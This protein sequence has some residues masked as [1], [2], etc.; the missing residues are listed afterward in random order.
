MQ[1]LSST[2]PFMGRSVL[3]R[4]GESYLIDDT[5]NANPDSM[6]AAIDLLCSLPGRRVLVLGDMGELGDATASGHRE[7]GAYAK[8]K[9]IDALLAT[10]Q[11]KQF[12]ADGFGNQA[13]LFPDHNALVKALEH[14]LQGVVSALIK[15]SRSA[16]MEQVVHA[17]TESVGAH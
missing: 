10:G 12:Y 1:G 16:R 2:R 8:M 13:Q 9:K 11:H 14:E 7:V 3:H 4:L 5:Y 15:G 6:K 17:V